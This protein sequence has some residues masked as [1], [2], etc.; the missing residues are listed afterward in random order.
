MRFFCQLFSRYS[1]MS[2][3][4]WFLSPFFNQTIILVRKMVLKIPKMTIF[5]GFYLPKF[6]IMVTCYNYNLKSLECYRKSPLLR[7]PWYFISFTDIVANIVTRYFYRHDCRYFTD[8]FSK[9]T[10]KFHDVV[11]AYKISWWS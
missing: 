6:L 10:A 2:R 5:P 7:P 1:K 11:N 3:I 4:L 8:T 9:V